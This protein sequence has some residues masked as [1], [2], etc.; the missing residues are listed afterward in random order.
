MLLSM[1]PYFPMAGLH[2]EESHQNLHSSFISFASPI[3]GDLSV[4]AHLV[5]P[6]PP[7]RT[8]RT[9][10]TADPQTDP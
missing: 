2:G 3:A 1:H 10:I 9:H 4:L 7:P 6:Q 8:H 5:Q